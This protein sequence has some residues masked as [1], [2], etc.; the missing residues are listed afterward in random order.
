MNP[1]LIDRILPV[2]VSVE[3]LIFQ[4]I[5]H[6]NSHNKQEYWFLYAFTS[7]MRI[8]YLKDPL[9]SI[10]LEIQSRA[11]SLSQQSQV[12]GHLQCYTLGAYMTTEVRPLL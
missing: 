12:G 11:S 2:N 5:A 10:L 1:E 9:K 8:T 3:F 7:F 4:I 6:L